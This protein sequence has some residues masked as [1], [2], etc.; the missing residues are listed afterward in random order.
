MY[1]RKEFYRG[2]KLGNESR[3]LS[4]TTYNNLKRLF[5]RSEE[6]KILVPVRKM[7]YLAVVK[8]DEIVFVDI[9][10]QS[11]IEF[12]W[13]SFQPHSRIGLSS[14]VDF[15]FCW[16]NIKAQETMQRMPNEFSGAIEAQ[17]EQL[18]KEEPGTGNNL[19]SFPNIQSLN[20][21][22]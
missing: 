8:K 4:A 13:Y 10:L 16:Y 12:A 3:T 20:S 18:R 14:P 1:Q 9:H 22:R 2:E 15:Q 7:Q 5:K 11:V 17:L 21:A 6:S 19:L